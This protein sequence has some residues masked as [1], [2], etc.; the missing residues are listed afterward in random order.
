MQQIPTE[1]SNQTVKKHIPISTYETFY[2]TKKLTNSER[3]T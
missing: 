1:Y 2:Y 3:I